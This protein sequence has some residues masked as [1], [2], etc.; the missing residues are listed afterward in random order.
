[1]PW[2][3]S[4]TVEFFIHFFDLV[5]PDSLLMAE[6]SKIRGHILEA[7]NSTFIALIPKKKELES[8]K[9][10]RPISLCNIIYKFI[11]KII[12]VQLKSTLSTYISQE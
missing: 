7:I 10:Y 11:S 4:W 8:F 12:A 1:M 5:G 9:D 2:P 3:D 6:E